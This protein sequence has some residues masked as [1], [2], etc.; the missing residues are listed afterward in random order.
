MRNTSTNWFCTNCRS[1]TRANRGRLSIRCPFCRMEMIDVGS[2]NKIPR[3]EKTK[4][5]LKELRNKYSYFFDPKGVNN[6]DI[7]YMVNRR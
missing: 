7:F 2:W 5:F 6:E 3:K 4:R 1:F